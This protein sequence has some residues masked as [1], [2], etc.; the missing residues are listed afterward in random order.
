MF[1][2]HTVL[3]V[4]CSLVVT[5]WESTDLLVLLYVMVS[6]VFVTFPYGVLGQVCHL[7]V[8]IPDLSLLPY[9][10]CVKETS[11]REVVFF[12]PKTNAF[13]ESYQ[14]RS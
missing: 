11:Q 2:C 5:C 13:I 6:C 12:S 3:C 1:V 9:I 4:P 14:T 10:G 7:I 8:S